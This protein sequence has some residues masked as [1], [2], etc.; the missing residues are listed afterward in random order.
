MLWNARSISRQ[1][2]VGEEYIELPQ[3]EAK[4]EL[5]KTTVIN[6]VFEK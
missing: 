1:Q 6:F 2:L 5:G 4:V 3:K